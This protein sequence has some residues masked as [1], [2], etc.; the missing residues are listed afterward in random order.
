MPIHLMLRAVL[1]VYRHSLQDE[2]RILLLHG[3]LHLAGHDHEL[4]P[5]EEANMA[6]QE[7]QVLQQ[8]GWKVRCIMK[9]LY[10]IGL[11][12]SCI[13]HSCTVTLV[14]AIAKLAKL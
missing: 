14:V 3:L 10:L 11:F 1:I 9:L 12:T 5:D 8:L 6:K 13:K 7:Q 2:C 4:G